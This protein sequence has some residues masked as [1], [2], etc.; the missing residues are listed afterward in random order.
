MGI[1]DSDNFSDQL[2]NISSAFFGD[3][4]QKD[5]THASKLMRSDAFAYA[6]NYK[7]LFH[8]YFTLNVQG[9][10]GDS[11]LPGAL[12]KSV[13]LP[14]FNLETNNYVQYN[15]KRLVHSKIE[16]QPVQVKFHD[17]ASD[18]IRSLWH[19]YYTY[20]FADAQYDY[21]Q[22]N[23]AGYNK[24]DQYDQHRP[25]KQ[26]GVTTASAQGAI[27]PAFFKDI[28]IYGMSRGNWICYTL[29]NPLIT[30]WRHD[31]YDYA[32]GDGVMEHNAEISYEAVKYTRVKISEGT[33]IGFAEASRYDTTK[34]PLSNPGTSASILGQAGAV[35]VGVGM[36]EDLASGNILGAIKKG[37]TFAN[38]IKNAD[39]SFGEILETD[40]L[41]EA[42]TQLPILLK[43]LSGKSGSI[44]PK[45]SSSTTPS[46]TGIPANVTPFNGGSTGGN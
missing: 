23:S 44:F 25:T 19:N 1:F 13:V 28:K 38:T 37:G 10:T 42:K 9:V 35:D 43:T 30:A 18:T 16:Y 14:S 40:V 5:Y 6:P 33:P 26:W 32:A 27:K 34:S 39:L 12:V 4:Y 45:A 20:Y 36:W 24:R 15:R 41:N 8:V 11:G 3:A 7:F 46:Q 31:T 2:G 29:I 17:D 22:G 21:E